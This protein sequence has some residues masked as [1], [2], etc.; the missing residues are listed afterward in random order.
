MR[1]NPEQFLEDTAGW[2]ES[3]YLWSIVTMACYSRAVISARQHEQVLFYCQAVDCTSQLIGT[4]KSDEKIYKQMLALPNIGH[5]KRLPGWVMLHVGMR[6]RLTT[7]VLLPWAVQDSVGTV[8]EINL[9]GQDRQRLASSADSHLDAEVLL[10]E[11]P[12]GVYVKLDNCNHEFLPPRP[13]EQHRVERGSCCDKCTA[14][15]SFEGWVLVEP[16]VGQFTYTDPDAGFTLQVQ[17]TQLPLMPA[18]ACPLYA[19]Q[20][21]TCDPGLIAHFVMPRRADDDIKWLIVYV[22]LSRVR[23]LSRLRS[24]GLNSKIRDIIEGGPPAIVA[25]NFEK[26][27]RK[28]ILDTHKAAVASRSA[29]GWQ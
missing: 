3:C 9:S 4:R 12:K 25:E 23:S 13:C 2:Y 19:L 14:C 28:K 11:L 29:L 8:V 1:R 18:A 15:R 22:M 20:G 27:F 6:V 7:T 21:A 16:L 24:L 26:L 17:R 10:Q 5:T